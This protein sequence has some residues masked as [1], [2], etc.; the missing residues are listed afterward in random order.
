MRD[1]AQNIEI[2]KKVEGFTDENKKHYEKYIKEIRKGMGNVKRGSLQI[3]ACLSVV[4]REGYYKIGG[5]SNVYDFAKEEFGLSK[6][7]CNQ[8]INICEK[9]CRID[10]NG[11]TPGLKE[12]Y[13]KYGIS[14]LRELLAVDEVHHGEFRPDMTI[15][16]M[17][18]KKARLNEPLLGNGNRKV[19]GIVKKQDSVHEYSYASYGEMIEQLTSMKEE[20]VSEEE[21]SRKLTLR[22]VIEKPCLN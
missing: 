21:Q 20:L 5:F 3:G 7:S 8:F 14:Q 4:K 11:V 9:F 6:G 16:E 15:K 10:E 18:E 2:S 19:E 17:K 13:E 22:I 12:E 1:L